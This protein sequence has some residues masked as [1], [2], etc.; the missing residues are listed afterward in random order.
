MQY[1]RTFAIQVLNALSFL[2]EHHIIHSDIKP[3]NVL[4]KN[5]SKTGIK[6]IDFG[7]SMFSHEATYLYVQSRFYRAPEVILGAPYDYAIDMWSAGCLLAEL[8]LGAPLF[9]GTNEQE[10]LSLIMQ[11]VGTPSK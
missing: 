1:I 2:K 4:L 8:Y 3:E 11:M 9:A 5:R 7:T 6:L 10:Q